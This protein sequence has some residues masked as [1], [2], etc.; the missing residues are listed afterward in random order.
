M[1]NL[2]GTELGPYRVLEQIGSGGMATVYRAYH[3]TMDRYVAIKVLPEQMSQD[4]ELISRF[5]REAQVIAK[6]EHAHILP[7]YDYGESTGRLY[8]V[9]RYIAAGTL[10]E[11]IAHGPM[12]LAEANRVV[13]Q[14][15]GALD[16]AHHLGVVHR[17]IKP[18]N[19]LID[20]HGN[21]Y[22]ADFGLARILE[23][24]MKLTATGV[25][26]G[27]PA[28]MSPEQ[29]QG[30]QADA[31]SDIYSLGVMLYEMVT[32]QVPYRAETPMAVVLQHIT[33]PLPLPS[34]VN[35]DVP[36]EI[37]RV[38]LKAM[39][40]DP[41]DRFQT[42]AALAAAFDA[43][44]RSAQARAPQEHRTPS[45]SAAAQPPVTAAAPW[46]QAP[47]RKPETKGA[48]WVQ[49]VLWAAGGL[50]ALL[51][52]IFAL[53]R[54]PL[55]VQIS[56]GRLEVLR[57]VEGTGTAAAA[58]P[59]STPAIQ[60]TLTGTPGATRA[61]GTA[62][63]APTL[64]PIRTS[65]AATTTPVPAAQS[66]Q[67]W[68]ALRSFP[69]PGA[70]PSMVIRT[71]DSLRVVTASD[72]QLYRLDLEG[73]ILGQVDI[74]VGC[75][76]W[77]WDGESLW[78]A[79]P[80]NGYL[81]R[82]DPATGQE[83]SRVEVGMDNIVGMTWDGSALW[84]VNVNGTLASYDRGGQRLRQLAVSV[85]GGIVGMA[86]VDGEL[87]IADVFGTVTRFDSKFNKV[88]SFS[89][90]QC[91]AG[92]FPFEVAMFWDGETLWLAD[93]TQNRIIQCQPTVGSPTPAVSSPT[94]APM[95]EPS[96][97]AAPTLAPTAIPWAEPFVPLTVVKQEGK[98]V[99]FSPDGKLLAVAGRQIVLYDTQTWKPV[100]TITTDRGADGIVFS[101]DGKT[102]AAVMGKLSLFDVAT[103][104][105]RLTLPGV[106]FGTSAAGSSFVSFSPDGQTLAVVVDEV[107]KLFEV[108]SGREIGL[109]LAKG[110]R[111]I[112]FSPDGKTL[113]TAGWSGGVVLWDAKSSQQIRTF[114]ERLGANRI[115]FSP[116]GSKLATAGTGSE[117][118]S[119]WEVSS[120]RAVQ[121]FRGHTGTANSLA[122]SPDGRLLATASADVTVKLWEVATGRELQTLLGHTRGVESA[123]FS[124][125]GAT[126]ATA[127]WDGTARL[128]SVAQGGATPTPQPAPASSGPTMTPVPPSASAI[129]PENAAQVKQATMVKQEGKA[130]AF[131]PDGKLL[132]V[133]GHQIILHDTQAWK[134]VRTIAGE[135]G[136]DGIVFSPDGKT[137]AA[138]MG[139]LS[140]FDVATGAE[141]LTLPGVEFSTSAA[142]SS[143][144]SFSPDG[145]TLA[146]VVDEVAK[147]F[148]TQSG[149]EIGLILAKGP[150][151]IAFSPD[152]KTLA[153]AG[154]SGG[155]VL[156]DIKSSQQIPTF[157]ALVGANRIAFTPDGSR[158][159][160]IEIGS[161]SITLWEVSSGRALQ[162]FSGHTG[163]VNSMA[164]SPDGRLLATASADVTVKLWEVATG[165]E[166]Q[167]LLGHT[168]AVESV[169]FSPDGATLATVSWDGTT[170]LWG[171]QK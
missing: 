35:P 53:S 36:P 160:T 104:A 152:G 51:I 133:A 52:L 90:S 55:K 15:S 132:A 72:R 157:G 153:T 151:A 144:V 123:A 165:R 6:L 56:G 127:S 77:G 103:G 33:A 31:R 29:G 108:Q 111:A 67:E 141:R 138:V 7:V 149:R 20:A 136:A 128:W 155:V 25:G 162:T 87:W 150:Y 41:N 143:F 98:A 13:S 100:R 24:S 23:A 101:P 76:Q 86:W 16:Y 145:Q 8:L 116:D 88:S 27:T 64:T 125:D 147:L 158:L 61:A 47:V 80:A 48:S 42:A 171:V 139:K 166:L 17:D 137:L 169:A 95:V 71:G 135:R 107:V 46:S 58:A 115:T 26:V 168:K 93:A 122:F 9:M 94:V 156:W 142:G 39:A 66:G 106:E 91:G 110:P 78:G 19:V 102:L 14:V 73:N 82:V 97:T 130:V 1:A 109:I 148:E 57:I 37:E 92:P 18:S 34:R 74:I 70:H 81:V 129:S 134:P 167:T 118:I 120:G 60:P 45:L 146:V 69:A 54:I 163:T 84:I 99:A 105:E 22:L 75:D 117:P 2:E 11:H 68:T 164:F 79:C 28:Y 43:A 170:R 38:I 3:A 49:P 50:V 96:A 65:P 32:G 112:A 121:T 124:P 12:G 44:V 63:L 89:L 40:K 62:T 30:E 126:L 161:D 113:A 159:A 4:P 131:S 83:L 85:F 5:R 154:W 114:G 59:T 10:K 119:L 140:L 21:C